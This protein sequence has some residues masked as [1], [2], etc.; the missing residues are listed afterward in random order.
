MAKRLKRWRVRAVLSL[1]IQDKV[2][3]KGLIQNFEA[4]QREELPKRGFRR[5]YCERLMLYS[6]LGPHLLFISVVSLRLAPYPE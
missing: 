6:N 1:K 2:L 4:S 3:F 5:G